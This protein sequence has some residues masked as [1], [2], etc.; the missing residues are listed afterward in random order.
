MS[1]NK[2][3][4]RRLTFQEVQKELAERRSKRWKLLGKASML[5]GEIEQ[6]EKILSEKWED[7]EG[8]KNGE[9]GRGVY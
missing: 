5:K 4:M 9:S 1:F 6:L 2:F 7:M 8:D 3:K